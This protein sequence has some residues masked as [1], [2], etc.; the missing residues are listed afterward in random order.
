MNSVDAARRSAPAMRVPFADLSHQWTPIAEPV[1][2]EMRQL[3]AQSAFSLGPW[4]DRFEQAVADYLGVAQAIGVNS[5][6][7]AL[8]LALIAAGIR[9][10]DE[11]LLPSHTFVATAWAVLYV[12]ARPVLCDVEPES[13]TIDVADAERRV[14]EA[15]RAIMPV[16]L[17]GQ[18]A[19]MAEVMKLAERHGLVVVEDAAQAIGAVYDGR[20]L[21]TI[22]RFGCYSFYPA[23]NLGAA[24]EAGLVVTNDEA[25]AKRMRALRHH[26]QSE[27]Y[28][29]AEV[30]FNYRMEGVQGLVLKHK[31]K[32]LPGWIEERRELARA[33]DEQ[34]RGLPLALPRVVHQDHVFHLYVV[35]T[36]DRDALRT[37]LQER[38]IETG[39]HYP[40][41]LHRQPCFA[42]M[43][44]DPKDFPACE[45]YT[46]ELLSLPLFTGMTRDQLDYVCEAVRAFYHQR[47]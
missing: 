43:G 44:F 31:L 13:G 34:L 4:V 28:V 26:A 40:I 35:R 11:V 37:S 17:Y 46:S 27:R 41:P 10:G 21:G 29:H 14:T 24:G 16:H 25:A 15:T 3:F 20:C 30:G 18:A 7:S 47:R 33:Y 42:A 12:G 1:M 8:H 23:K 36:P 45:R 38:G 9:P 2:A 6:T 39:L 19:N 22:G 5:G 32:L